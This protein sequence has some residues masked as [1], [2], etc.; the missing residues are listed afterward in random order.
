MH[1]DI[2]GPIQQRL[3]DLAGE[4]ALAADFLQRA[5]LNGVARHLDDADGKGI[6]GQVKRGH[7]PRARLMRL[8]KCQRGSTGAD[9]ER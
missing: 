7:Q 3:F 6:L 2:D 4:Q 9:V 5:V 8:R 1:G